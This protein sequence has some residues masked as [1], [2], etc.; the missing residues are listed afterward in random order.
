MNLSKLCRGFAAAAVL[1]AW[2]SVAPAQI[3]G[4]NPQDEIKELF[5]KVE[6]DLQ[7]IDELL[8]QAS[9][10]SRGAA[11]EENK[12]AATSAHGKQKAVSENIQK[13]I[14]L[15]P[16]SGG[17]GGNSGGHGLSK[18]QGG[19][20]G[21]QQ[22]GQNGKQQNQQGQKP[23]GQQGGDSAGQQKQEKTAEGAGQAPSTPQGQQPSGS[24]EPDSP[25]KSNAT[26]EQSTGKPRNYET[27]RVNRSKEAVERWGDLPEHAQRAFSNQNTEDLP[28]RY[29]KWIQDF[30]LRMQKS[31]ASGK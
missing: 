11:A 10:E 3:P 18:P 6:K 9:S 14:D 21:G 26:P 25:L 16:P 1:A 15:I 12:S 5:K 22:Q 20:K 28:M 2:C 4:S 7:E 19:G 8:Q 17:G 27:D 31:P 24:G 29:R 30:Y 23:Q 13:I